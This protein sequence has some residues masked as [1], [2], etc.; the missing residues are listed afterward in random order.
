MT[1]TA[2]ETRT[3]VLERTLA[4][5]PEKI[6]RAL[7]QA[8]LIEEWLMKT[9][10]APQVGHRFQFRAE[11]AGGWDGVIQSE[12]LE[13]EP[14]GSGGAA[15]LV[16]SWGSMGLESTVT[17]TLTPV[18]GGTLVRMEQAGFRPDQ[19]NNYRGAQYGWTRFLDNLDRVVGALA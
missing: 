1:E 13:I 6:W 5:P 17:W 15:R 7:T 11:P 12:V 3:L 16:Y 14:A 2:A 10:F 4:H 8:P 9:D 18:G 19:D